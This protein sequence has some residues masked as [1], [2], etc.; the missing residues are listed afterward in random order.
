VAAQKL[1][2]CLSGDLD[3]FLGSGRDECLT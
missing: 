1:D 3:R 2:R